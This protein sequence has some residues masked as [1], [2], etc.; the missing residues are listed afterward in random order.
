[1]DRVA[2]LGH[3]TR[4]DMPAGVPAD[5]DPSGLGV[6][7]EVVV[8]ADDRRRGPVR[9]APVAADAQDV[10]IR[11]ENERVGRVHVHFPQA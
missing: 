3:G 8:R 11:D 4:R 10:V 9:G 1:M 7:Q 5:G 6:C 2:G